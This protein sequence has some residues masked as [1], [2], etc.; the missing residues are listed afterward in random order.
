LGFGFWVRRG[1]AFS[2]QYFEHNQPVISKM[3]RPYGL[4]IASK[5][6]GR[7]S[8]GLV[9][10]TALGLGIAV[11]LKGQRISIPNR[12]NLMNGIRMEA[13]Y[14]AGTEEM[15]A[16]DLDSDGLVRSIDSPPKNVAFF[17]CHLIN[18]A[19]GAVIVNRGQ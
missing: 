2:E 5:R 6:L 1:E 17:S 4:W 11:E 16:S 10:K 15:F 14:V 3:P 19:P 18:D 8:F 12:F 9:L 7:L 13:D